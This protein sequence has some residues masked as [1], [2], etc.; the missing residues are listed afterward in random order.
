MTDDQ[1]RTVVLMF[2]VLF[3]TIFL[4]AMAVMIIVTWQDTTLRYRLI[5][6]LVGVAGLD[7]LIVYL[8]LRDRKSGGRGPGEGPE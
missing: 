2:N 4:S 7:A 1:R 6:V 5:A 8:L 3:G